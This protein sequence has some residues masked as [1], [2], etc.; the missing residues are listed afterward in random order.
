[1]N[2]KTGAL[3]KEREKSVLY[4]YKKLKGKEKK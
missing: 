1:M 3:A 2:S 4:R